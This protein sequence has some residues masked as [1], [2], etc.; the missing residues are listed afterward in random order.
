MRLSI[1]LI[2]II[3]VLCS[4]GWFYYKD[5]QAIIQD[6]QDRN[7]KLTVA[8]EEQKQAIVAL[9]KHAE[10]QAAQVQELQTGLNAANKDKA[11]LEKTLREHDLAALAR[12]NP[13]VLEDKMN[14]ATARVWR[15]LEVTTGAEPKADPSGLASSDRSNKPDPAPTGAAKPSSTKTKKTFKKLEDVN[16]AAQ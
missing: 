10:E 2:V 13:K 6:L 11:Q 4:V 3:G 15:D 1:I 9:N 7:A 8:V 12:A 5:T 16:A 14:K